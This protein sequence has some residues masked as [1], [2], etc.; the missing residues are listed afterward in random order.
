MWQD[1]CSW[2]TGMFQCHKHVEVNMHDH[3]S[4]VH[5]HKA[6]RRSLY[7]I[8]ILPEQM[9]HQYRAHAQME[10]DAEATPLIATK[11][12]CANYGDLDVLALALPPDLDC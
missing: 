12:M 4:T 9:A 10:A 6:Q 8:I 2:L 3:L 11:C 7:N 5:A 1:K